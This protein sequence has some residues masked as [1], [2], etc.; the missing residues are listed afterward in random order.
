MRRQ[1]RQTRKHSS[2]IVDQ[3]LIDILVELFGD[4]PYV[5]ITSQELRDAI[6]IYPDMPADVLL[7]KYQSLI[8]ELLKRDV[9]FQ[10][11]GQLRIDLW[12]LS[13]RFIAHEPPRTRM[14]DFQLA[15]AYANGKD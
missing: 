8:R 13:A 1:K 15:L 14:S 7:R 9:W 3:Q 11:G 6:P 5:G 10:L 2:E 12:R 4:G